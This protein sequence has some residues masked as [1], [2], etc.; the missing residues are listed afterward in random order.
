MTQATGEAY[1]TLVCNTGK[2]YELTVLERAA[3]SETWAVQRMSWKHRQ[4]GG[5]T[6]TM[7]AGTEKAK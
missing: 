5:L 3:T 2:G 1:E 6:P 4:R 7:L